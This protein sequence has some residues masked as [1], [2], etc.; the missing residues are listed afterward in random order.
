[1]DGH[2]T[3][4]DECMRNPYMGECV[5]QFG[6]PIQPFMVIGSY[7]EGGASKKKRR[8]ETTEEERFLNAGAL[9]ITY[10]LRNPREG[11]PGAAEAKA[12]AMAWE[13]Q[14]LGLLANYSSPLIRVAYTT[15][16]SIED[17]IERETYADIKII[18]L[19]YLAMFFYLTVTLG[20]YSSCCM[21]L[22]TVLLETK[23]FLA[24]GGV[25]IVLASVF[26][27]GGIFVYL[28]VPVIIIFKI[29]FFN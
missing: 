14:V 19:S 28:G 21:D 26:S 8:E 23:I 5:S 3:H 22:R 11:E 9:V 7:K 17:E 12:R 24:L 29:F 6:A 4:V 16:R 20:K 25:L 10:V 2:L 13:A 18:A 1:M 15:E 27:S